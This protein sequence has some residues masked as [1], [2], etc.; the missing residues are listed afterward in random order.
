MNDQNRYEEVPQK[1]N[2]F[3]KGLKAFGHYL[4]Y[5]FVDFFNSFKYNNMKLAA[6]LFAMPGILLGFFMF[7]HVPSIRKVVVSYDKNV[8]EKTANITPV[9]DDSTAV[10]NDFVLTISQ[11]NG[12][13]NIEMKLVTYDDMKSQDGFNQ[14]IYPIN[15]YSDSKTKQL[16]TPVVSSFT[17]TSAANDEHSDSY[18]I[19]VTGLDDELSYVSSYAL[20]V[21]ESVKIGETVDN[22]DPANP[23][24][25]PIYGD[26][27]I[28]NIYRK[29]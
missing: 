20:F 10:N 17:D 18:A 12:Y 23:I 25:T 16:K 26:Y 2:K 22:T 6:I 9:L 27:Y 29:F 8:P 3:V 1:E 15:G 14:D 11:Y 4:K 28:S 7:A 21:F 24:T 13:E 19:T 5:V